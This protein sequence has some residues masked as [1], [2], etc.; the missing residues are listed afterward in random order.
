MT[1]HSKP[2]NSE[3]S[4]KTRAQITKRS[5]AGTKPGLVVWIWRLEGL[6]GKKVIMAPQT[7]ELT[8]GYYYYLLSQSSA[9]APRSQGQRRTTERKRASLLQEIEESLSGAWLPGF[10]SWRCP[11]WRRCFD[12]L[13]HLFVTQFLAL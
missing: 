10:E 2:G 9:E 12:K 6:K 4:R 3:E 1:V 8:G 5:P 7:Y 13:V 11:C